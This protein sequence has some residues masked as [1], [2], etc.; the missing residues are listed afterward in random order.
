MA[1]LTNLSLNKSNLLTRQIVTEPLG[2]VAKAHCEYYPSL[3]S[4]RGQCRRGKLII[5]VTH[6]A[7]VCTSCIKDGKT[8]HADYKW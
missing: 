2:M 3:H 6:Y 1:F 4:M 8:T 7:N 5:E